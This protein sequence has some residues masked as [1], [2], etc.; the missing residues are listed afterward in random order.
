MESSRAVANGVVYLGSWDDNVYALDASTGAKLWS[1]ATGN[2][3]RSSPA[4]SDGA[5]YI[6]SEDGKFYALNG[7]TGAELWRYTILPGE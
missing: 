1:Y 6:G 5:V 3:L 7:S 4:V 2:E